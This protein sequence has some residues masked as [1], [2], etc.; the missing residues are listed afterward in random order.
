L[1]AG[2]TETVVRAL[3]VAVLAAAAIPIAFGQTA[4]TP[5]PHAG[6]PSSWIINQRDAE[7][8]VF[9]EQVSNITGRTL[10]LDPA[11]KG[12]VTVISAEPLDANGVWELFQSVLRVNGF[13]ALKA[14]NAWRIVPQAAVNQ[15]GAPL[16]QNGQ[17][18]S[19]NLITRLIMLRNLPSEAAARVLRPLVASF[20]YLEALPQPNAIVVTDNAENVSRIEELARLLD[21]GDG[22][23]V[24]TIPLLHGSAKSIA[25]LIERTLAAQGNGSAAANGPRVVA[26]ERSNSLIVRAD[27]TAMA[28]ISEIVRRLDEANGGGGLTTRVFR[29]RHADAEAVTAILKGLVGG[30]GPSEN[31]VANALEQ[32]GGS[33]QSPLSPMAQTVLGQVLSPQGTL[34]GSSP[35]TPQLGAGGAGL[36]LQGD[37]GGPGGRGAKGGG[38][39]FSSGDLAIQPDPSLNAIV[40]R[41]PPSVVAEIDRLIQDLDLRRP[42]VLIEAAIVEITGDD[43]ENFGVQIGAGAAAPVQGGIAATSFS[44]NGVSIGQVLT[45]LGSPV[46]SVL[47]QDGLTLGYSKRNEFSVLVQALATSSKA[48]LLST[49]SLTTLDNEPAEIIV[50]QNVPFVTGSYTTAG[51]TTPFTTIQRQDVGITLKVV[52]RVTDGDVI[53]LQVNQEVSSISTT[54]VAGASDLITNKRNIQTTILADNGQTIVLGGLISDNVMD[55]NSRIPVLGNIPVLGA[56]FGDTQKSRDKQT[57]YVFLRTTILRDRAAVAAAAGREYDRVRVLDATP[58]ENSNL[59]LAPTVPKLPL[60]IEGIY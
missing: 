36:E 24:E 42:Q 19:Q 9:A 21:R 8:R 44:A 2:R 34:Q 4:N 32:G 29:L 23:R 39:G 60:D 26:D 20:G 35:G 17:P 54:P 51:T 50:G 18:A 13:A 30:K 12:Q 57:L 38:G 37:F 1:P 27:P 59:L 46:A 7:L 33:S 31:P 53:R 43:S 49:P 5:S 47:G 41:G 11:V 58:P 14:G 48:N 25:P 56:L 6:A 40:V 52:P 16:D 55:S 45:A 15:G 3:L 22:T 28:Q 10:I